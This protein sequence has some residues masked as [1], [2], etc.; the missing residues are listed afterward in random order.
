MI[1][2]ANL[3]LYPSPIKS[4]INPKSTITPEPIKKAFTNPFFGRRMRAVVSTPN[5][6]AIPPSLGIDLSCT[7]LRSGISIAWS[8]TESFEKSGIREIVMKI[9]KNSVVMQRD[10]ECEF[11][12]L[13]L[14]FHRY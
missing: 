7:F 13:R 11:Y 6:M 12:V 8:W 10:T 1:W 9:E 5:A 3:F 14:F 2:P 4:S